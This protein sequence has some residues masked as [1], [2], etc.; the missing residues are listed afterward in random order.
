MEDEVKMNGRWNEELFIL[1]ML[2]FLK[3]KTNILLT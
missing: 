1:I 2:F 3:P